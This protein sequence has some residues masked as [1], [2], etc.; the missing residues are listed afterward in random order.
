MY[1]CAEFLLIKNKM[2][3][4]IAI[5]VHFPTRKYSKSSELHYATGVNFIY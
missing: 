1:Y 4:K 3:A 5:V 2:K